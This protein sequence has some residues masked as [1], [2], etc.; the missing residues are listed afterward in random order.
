M[1]SMNTKRRVQVTAFLFGAAATTVLAASCASD[2]TAGSTVSEACRACPTHVNDGTASCDDGKTSCEKAAGKGSSVCSDAWVQCTTGVYEN[3]AKCERDACHNESAA[4][5]Y[6]KRATQAACTTDCTSTF[7]QSSC[8]YQDTACRKA[9][10]ATFDECYG[11]CV[12]KPIDGECAA[13]CYLKSEPATLACG[14]DMACVEQVLNGEMA[15]ESA[16][17]TGVVPGQ[18]GAGQG[19]AGQGGGAGGD[20]SCGAGRYEITDPGT[21]NC[22]AYDGSGLVV[23]HFT[24][25][26]WSRSTYKNKWLTQAQADAHCKSTGARLPTKDE[27]L[28]VSGSA[29]QKC[30]W[31]CGWW[32]WTST[33]A[34]DGR[35]WKVAAG[36][37]TYTEDVGRD[38]PVLCVR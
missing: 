36:G 13:D 20:A 5:G 11:G 17:G 27:A 28:A 26:T 29:F 30:A 3:G 32:T 14:A 19:G 21:G 24:W 4:A 35:A 37:E 34:G 23:D 10:L 25:L 7:N 15:C 6:E 22:E 12:G 31:P 38:V 18:G 16:C 1:V 8:T 9:A 2:S 33:P